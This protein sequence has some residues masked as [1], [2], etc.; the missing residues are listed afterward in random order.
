[1]VVRKAVMGG[2]IETSGKRLLQVTQAADASA[3][4]GQPGQWL[5]DPYNITV[6]ADT[7][8]L[9]ANGPTFYADSDASTVSATVVNTALSAGTD[10]LITIGVGD[11]TDTTRG[12]ITVRRLP[13][14]WP[15][16]VA[17]PVPP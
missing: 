5:L 7:G 16:P 14:R 1:M 12:H 2:R 17:P 15:P 4:H 3:P 11:G 10:V 6:Q 8:S 9:D 13:S